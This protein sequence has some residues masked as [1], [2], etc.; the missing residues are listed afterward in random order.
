MTLSEMSVELF[1]L[2]PLLGNTMQTQL[3]AAIL[4]KIRSG[5]ALP[6]AKLPS[7]RKLAK[8][9]G[10]SRP[11]V[12]LAYQELVS[13]GFIVAHERSAYRIAD[14]PPIEN[15]ISKYQQ[16]NMGEKPSVWQHRLKSSVIDERR[17]IRKPRDWRGFPYPFI[18]GQMDPEVFEISAWQD[19]SRKAHSKV[20]F[21]N[22]ASD[23]VAA[24]DPVL[25]ELIR[26]QLLPRRGIHADH[27]EILITIGAQNALWLSVQLLGKRAHAVCE[28]P[29]YPDI[30]TMLSLAENQISYVDIGREGLKI[31][32]IPSN[33]DVVFAS[34]SHQAPT[35]VTMPLAKR[36]HLLEKASENDFII[37]EDDYDFEIRF[38]SNPIKSLKSMDKDGRVVYIGSFS[39][40]MFPGVRIGYMVADREFIRH[41]RNI[42]ALM[43]RHPAGLL[44]RTVANFIALGHYD[45]HHQRI[46]RILTQRRFALL[47]ALDTANIT[48]IAASRMGGSSLWIRAPEGIDSLDLAERLYPK[49]VLIEP[50]APFFADFTKPHREFRLGYSSISVEKIMQGVEIVGNEIF[51]C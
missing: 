19:C 46:K 29:G 35:G 34:P 45:T 33:A 15:F 20:D 43:L 27:E 31:E 11:T 37:V 24:D 30:A 21:A 4:N 28:N 14:L 16:K 49:G 1:E 17:K 41:A 40:S 3:C 26:T 39:K 44:Q 36:E 48:D 51:A 12:S 47:E 50:G 13:Q 9:L 8:Y 18:Y 7:S 2:D 25:V 42:R 6:G 22:M 32:Q 10:V 38:L 23:V 5:A